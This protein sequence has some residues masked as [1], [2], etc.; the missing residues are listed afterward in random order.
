[1]QFVEHDAAQR[2]EHVRRI[3]GSQ[4]QR[5]LL[6]R[7]E[8]NVG[9]IAAL[10]LPLRGRRVAGARLQPDRQIH[11]AHRHFQIARDVDGERLQW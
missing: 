9:R 3:G 5:Q 7:G 2:A 4:Q 1:M 11:L 10:T 8:Q 6:R